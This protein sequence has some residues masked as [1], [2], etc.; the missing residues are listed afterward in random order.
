MQPA[1]MIRTS[2][3][4]SNHRRRG[5]DATCNDQDLSVALAQSCDMDYRK[6]FLNLYTIDIINAN[7]GTRIVPME[8]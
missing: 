8:S 4:H 3:L 2:V 6:R 1:I 5:D 7:Y